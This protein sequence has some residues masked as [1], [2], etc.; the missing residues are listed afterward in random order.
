MYHKYSLF[1]PILSNVTLTDELFILLVTQKKK[2][3]I[4]FRFK[5]LYQK[6]L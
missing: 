1:L 3:T 6:D 2:M 4:I 5:F